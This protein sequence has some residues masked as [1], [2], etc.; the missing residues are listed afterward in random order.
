MMAVVSDDPAVPCALPTP[1]SHA[2]VTAAGRG[3]APS[4]R[5][6]VTLRSVEMFTEYEPGAYVRFISP[7]P[8]LMV[9][10][11][12]DHLTVADE[13]LAAYGEALEAKALALLPGGHFDAYV[14]G[15]EQASAP[16]RG[17]VVRHLRPWPSRAGAALPAREGGFGAEPGSHR[18]DTP[19]VTNLAHRRSD[20]P[21]VTSADPVPAF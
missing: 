2:W 17:W 12:G 11:A 1:D 15:F 6:E 3:R 14:A 7:T 5:N 18:R 21:R 10:A 16:A 4:W 20:Q 19:R 8:L 13:A 9:V